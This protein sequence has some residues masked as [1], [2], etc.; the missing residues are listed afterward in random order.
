MRSVPSNLDDDLAARVP[1]L[2]QRVRGSDIG[3]GKLGPDDRPQQA[4]I[5]QAGQ[6]AQ[7]RRVVLQAEGAEEDQPRRRGGAERVVGFL[8]IPLRLSVFAVEDNHRRG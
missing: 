2:A 3:Q 8:T 4:V 6:L 7:D 1:A 5:D